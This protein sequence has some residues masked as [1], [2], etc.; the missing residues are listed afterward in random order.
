MRK[1]GE[2]VAVIITGGGKG[3]GIYNG[4]GIYNGIGLSGKGMVWIQCFIF[5]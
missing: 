2:V 3:S 1:E 5:Y 4:V